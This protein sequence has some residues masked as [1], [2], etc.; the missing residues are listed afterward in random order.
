MS[1]DEEL[2]LIDERG[3]LTG[4]TVKYSIAHKDKLPHRIS[5]VLVFRPNGNLL[6]QVHKYHDRKLDHSVGGHVSAGESFEQAAKRE[7]EEELGLDLPIKKI[8]E[9]VI[10]R[11]HYADKNIDIVHVFGI[12]SARVPDKWRH[13]ETEEVD[14][15]I[16]M[17]VEDIVKQMNETPDKFLQGF[18]TSLGTYLRVTGSSLRIRA[19]GKDWGEL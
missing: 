13:V 10:S 3:N 7:M 18:M 14:Q 11:E 1:Q 9:N 17:N 4:Q 16:E 6:V 2:D 15:L 12:Y 5:A 8:A 19:F